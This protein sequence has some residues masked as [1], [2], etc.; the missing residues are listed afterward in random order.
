MK[1]TKLLASGVAAALATTSLAAISVSATERTFDM[2]ITTGTIKLKQAAGY[3][4]GGEFNLSQDDI[5]AGKT[6]GVSNDDLLIIKP[7]DFGFDKMTGAT[8]KVTGVKGSRG[9]SPKTY[10]YDFYNAWQDGSEAYG[11]GDYWALK[12]YGGDKAPADKL[13][14][15]QYVEITKVEIEVNGERYVDNAGA[16][17]AWGTS[18]WYTDKGINNAGAEVTFGNPITVEQGLWN[19]TGDENI[20]SV[21]MSTLYGMWGL[22]YAGEK[23]TTNNYP[24]MA[25]TDLYQA[26]GSM[27]SNAARTQI[28]GD[29]ILTRQEI[30]ALSTAGAW[31]AGSANGYSYVLDSD[32]K[33]TGA[34]VTFETREADGDQTYE[35]AD[36]NQGTNPKEFAGLASQVADFFNKQTNGTI[37]FKFTTAAATSGTVWNNGG[38]PSTQ[39][40]LR[41]ALGDA[42]ANDFALFFNYQQT[43]S[44]EAIAEV[45]ADEGS[46]TFD[47]SDILD[48]LDGKTIGV[49]NNMYYGLTKGVKYDDRAMLGLKVESVTLAYEEDEDAGNDIE[50]DDDDT[51]DTD[52]EDDD[53]TSDDVDDDDDTDT[54]DDDDDDDDTGITIDDDDDDDD[55]DGQDVGGVVVTPADDDEGDGNPNTG[56]ALAVVPAMVAAAAVVVSKKRK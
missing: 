34:W 49:V 38:I 23:S 13:L 8:L 25:V 28:V 32:G 53:D 3:E 33:L 7:T 44:L 22:N 29:K 31:S 48:A 14:P 21:I 19:N 15:S 17:D 41:N 4:T 37:T 45:N 40:G 26:D 11:K 50:E 47:I 27:T 35:T 36:Y 18:A 46:V 54:D 10:N 9:V 24:F 12:I 52:D 1:M 42:T 16:Y 56:V 2:G 55:D 6:L 30:F 51:D 5:D 43:G 39:V 20:C